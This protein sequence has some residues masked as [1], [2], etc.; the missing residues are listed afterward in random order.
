MKNLLI[1]TVLITGV[2]FFSGNL[3]AS[4]FNSMTMAKD[5]SAFSGDFKALCV[6]ILFPAICACGVVYLLVVA[7]QT[8]SAKPVIIAAFIV[9]GGV[10]VIKM[11]DAA[12]GVETVL[13]P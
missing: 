6:N 13:M 10:F 8:A 3:E 2:M 12:N 11:A 7:F 4:T 9:A 5:V 1:L